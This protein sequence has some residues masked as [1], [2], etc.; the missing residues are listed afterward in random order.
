MKCS[1]IYSCWG[2]GVN[3]VMLATLKVGGC[4]EENSWLLGRK[5]DDPSRG[6][7]LGWGQKLGKEL[8]LFEWPLTR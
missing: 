2:H 5:L 3:L 7:R 1:S 4:T 6:L 8:S